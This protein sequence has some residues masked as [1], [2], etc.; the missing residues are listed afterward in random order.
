MW[1]ELLRAKIHRVRLT[2]LE[3]NYVGSVV[4]DEQLL[5]ATGILPHEKVQVLNINNGV[6]METYIIKGKK[7]SGMIGLNGPAARGAS[8]GDI[9]I[10]AAYAWMPIDI[11]QTFEPVV[12]F[13]DEDNKLLHH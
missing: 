9:L 12:V 10:I 6:R 4:V 2:S 1:I 13:P 3:L 5:E 8:V 11:A 7:G